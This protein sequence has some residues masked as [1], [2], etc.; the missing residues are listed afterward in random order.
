MLNSNASLQITHKQ[1]YTL[2]SHMYDFN[3]NNYNYNYNN[4]N[5][6]L[7]YTSYYPKGNQIYGRVPV[8]VKVI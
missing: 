5:N 7:R 6:K 3:S 8:T 2:A 1:G 4:N